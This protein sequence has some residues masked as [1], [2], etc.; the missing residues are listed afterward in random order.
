MK[1][2][3]DA[4]FREGYVTSMGQHPEEVAAYIRTEY[5]RC[6]RLIRLSGV[7]VD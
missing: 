6:D 3:N 2:L 4:E 5:E 1:I 7:K